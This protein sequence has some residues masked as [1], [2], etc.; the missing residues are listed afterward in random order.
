MVVV[1]VSAMV[2]GMLLLKEVALVPNI[3]Y[4]ASPALI[5]LPLGCG[6]QP[7]AVARP[8]N[9]LAICILT[10]CPVCSGLAD[11]T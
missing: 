3:V 2:G 5:W 10:T 7:R 4:V 8:S 11:L 9:P 1:E 6:A